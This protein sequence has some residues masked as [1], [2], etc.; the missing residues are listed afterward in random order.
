MTRWY[1]F[2]LAVKRL[3]F[4]S[5]EPQLRKILEWKPA[6]KPVPEKSDTE[7]GS[8]SLRRMAA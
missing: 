5:K 2:V 6:S 7:R 4:G 1:R 8:I 3:I